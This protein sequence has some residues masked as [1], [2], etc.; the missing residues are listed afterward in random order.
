MSW[1]HKIIYLLL[2]YLLPLSVAQAI[3]F[4]AQVE[5][6]L[7]RYQEEGKEV[8]TFNQLPSKADGSG[9]LFKLRLS[10]ERNQDWFFA[11]SAALMGS[12]S[13]AAE[14]WNNG[15]VND[16]SMRQQDVRLDMQYRM[17][18]ARFGIWL[19][20][21][22]QKQTRDNF[23]VNGVATVVAG[24]PI[25]EVVKSQW[26]GLSLTS[27]GGNV[28]QF[29]TRIDAALALDMN[30]TNPLFTAPFSKKNGYRTGIHFRWT[31]PKSE[32]G[33][34]GLN[35]TLRYEYQDIGGENTVN[36]GFWPYNR[37]QMVSMGLMYAW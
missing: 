10:S 30:V 18:G 8:T 14:T 20:Q 11:V 15:Q 12:G 24:A 31:L 37:W 34:S 33:V 21:R 32:V 13:P 28:G 26:A 23:V 29:E 36:N 3:E 2:A 16:L 19:A 5:R 4:D 22:E 9:A 17:L 1:V 6:V 7:W 25:D 35:I 27:V